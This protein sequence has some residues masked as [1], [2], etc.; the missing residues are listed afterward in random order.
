MNRGFDFPPPT[1][2]STNLSKLLTKKKF[3]PQM[4]KTMNYKNNARRCLPHPRALERTS[5]GCG[6]RQRGVWSNPSNSP[7]PCVRACQCR[8]LSVELQCWAC[9]KM[10]SGSFVSFFFSQRRYH[11]SQHLAD[12]SE[13][14]SLY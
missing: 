12:T 4:R 10:I 14:V 3:A 2:M 8:S 1:C 9:P 11:R 7:P 6:S 5:N 13:Y